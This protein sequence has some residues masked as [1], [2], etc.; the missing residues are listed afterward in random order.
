MNA[1]HSP[2]EYLSVYLSGWM[3]GWTRA[4]GMCSLV[5]VSCSQNKTLKNNFF[6]HK[7]S[8][9]GSMLFG[10]QC[11]SNILCEST[12]D[13][14][15]KRINASTPVQIIQKNHEMLMCMI[16]S[17]SIGQNVSFTVSIALFHNKEVQ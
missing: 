8:Q 9:W 4:L 17:G 13:A 10:P 11:S 1:N 12:H 15:E 16:H 5:F 3:D 14:K 6:A 2:V 7:M